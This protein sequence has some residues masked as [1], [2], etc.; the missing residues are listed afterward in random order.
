MCTKFVL[1]VV[2]LYEFAKVILQNACV[3]S[4]GEPGARPHAGNKYSTIL[5]PGAYLARLISEEKVVQN[6]VFSR[7]FAEEY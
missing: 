2:I 7:L 5:K 3:F 1:T 4:L 6:D